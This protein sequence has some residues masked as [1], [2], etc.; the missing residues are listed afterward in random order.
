VVSNVKSLAKVPA[1]Q[2]FPQFELHIIDV[3][4]IAVFWMGNETSFFP[5]SIGSPRC[6]FV[7]VNPGHRVVVPKIR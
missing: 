1:E 5:P 6:G 7:G 4:F 3:T 2:G